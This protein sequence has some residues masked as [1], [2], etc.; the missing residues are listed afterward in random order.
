MNND[1]VK[2]VASPCV[3]ICVLDE[4]DICSGCYRSIKEIAEWSQM[5]ENEK[6]ATV[7][8]AQ[9]RAKES[10]YWL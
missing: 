7:L 3:S 1:E 2:K 9:T 4:N 10:G 6:G 8:R 5:S